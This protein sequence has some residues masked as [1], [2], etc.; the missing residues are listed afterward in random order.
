[1]KRLEITTVQ[2]VTVKTPQV[3]QTGSTVEDRCLLGVRKLT[4]GV[5]TEKKFLCK[6]EWGRGDSD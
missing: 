1:M 3:L 5:D 4:D 6:V 2:Q